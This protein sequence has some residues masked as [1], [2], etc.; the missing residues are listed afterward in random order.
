M[1]T[2]PIESNSCRH[3]GQGTIVYQG[4]IEG[5]K[6]RAGVVC[7]LCGHGEGRRA[8]GACRVGP[9]LMMF[10]GRPSERTIER[11]A[12]LILEAETGGYITTFNGA[13]GLR[14]VVGRE[15]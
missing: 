10:T 4:Y 1:S 8:H 3:C 11:L 12:D 6:E 13:E 2:L 14:W 5:S 7:P 9:C 15:G